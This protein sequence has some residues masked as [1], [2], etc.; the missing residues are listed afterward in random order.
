VN[1]ADQ[2]G[3][4]AGP[5]FHGGGGMPFGGGGAPG[6]GGMHH[7]SQEEA[8]LL[9][10]HIFGGADPF[11]SAFGRRGGGGGGGP[12]MSFQQQGG[13]R[14]GGGNIGMDPFGS[15]FGGGPMGG[16][17]PGGSMNGRPGSFGMPQQR[18][19]QRRVKRYDTIP[20]GTVVS[21][22]GLQSQPER[23]GDRGEIQDYDDA[24]GRYI[25]QLEDSDE[26]LRVKPSNLLQHV[27]VTMQGIES[28]PELNGKRGTIIAWNDH[29]GR[30]QIYC[31]DMAKVLSLRP[32]NVV[33]ENGT[34]G[35]IVGLQ[36]K[37]QL[38]GKFGTIK[39]W[40]RTSNRYDV[41]ISPDQIL[42]LKA[43]NVRV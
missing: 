32:T 23:N 10:S 9:F 41:Y 34:V 42:R 31:M 24:S 16:G 1:Q 22:K 14:P 28:Q 6:G 19:P 17:F 2:M 13:P 27:H 29:K 5:H 15:M 25:V 30:Y 39:S 33:L 18:Q 7:M 37:P 12:R 38:N 21:L 36:A 26:C 20:A 11:G 3:E 35:H 4:A 40:D 8:D 43:E